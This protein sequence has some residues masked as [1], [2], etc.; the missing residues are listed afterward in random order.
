[1]KFHSIRR[2]ALSGLRR[3]W[4]VVVTALL[5][6]GGALAL[7]ALTAPLAVSANLSEGEREIAFRS[8]AI[9]LRFSQ[10][11]NVQSVRDSFRIEPAVPYTLSIESPRAFRFLPQLQPDTAYQVR[12]NAAHKALGLGAVSY[13]V[14]FRTEADPRVVTTTFDQA[15]IKDGQQAVPLRGELSVAFSQPMAENATT[16]TLD[17]VPLPAATVHWDATGQTLTASL[18]LR[19]SRQHTLALADGAQNRRRDPVLAPW[20][21]NF[22]TM[23]QVPSAGHSERIG[24]SGAPVLIQIENSDQASVRPQAGMQQAD[25][26]YEYISEYGI[27]RLT[28]VYWHP[29][30]SLI[31]PVRSCRLITVALEQMFHG[32]IYC[33]GANDYVLGQVWKHPSVV[34]D[35]SYWLP[36]MFRTGDRSAPHNVMARPDAINQHTAEARLPALPYDIAP[37]HDDVPLPGGTAGGVI[38][39]PA[40]ASVWRYDPGRREY[41]KWQDG[42]PL[43]NAGTGQ[44]HAKTVIVE[45][46]KSGL[47]TNPANSFHGYF[48]EYY[49]LA[50]EGAADIYSNG[51]VVHATWRHP[52]RA[53]PVVYYAPNGEP[54]DLNTGLTW[55]HVVGSDQ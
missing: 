55:V 2:R 36:F 41:L 37:A 8:Q 34:Y 6:V 9:V 18:S 33:S 21:L 1:M 50:G 30:S 31:G 40:H 35:Y 47:D 19:H 25:L 16:L 17:G 51:S 53:L 26:I 28:A 10:D 22:T 48:T 46:V 11:M 12:L 42:A 32:M 54:I 43:M 27:P 5:L 24:A 45:Q 3:R 4:W 23:V 14:S 13:A 15:P 20:T 52:D 29:L 39:I 44:V 38:T 49:E 7:R